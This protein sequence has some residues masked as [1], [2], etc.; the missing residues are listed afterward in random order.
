MQINGIYGKLCLPE[1]EVDII[2][3]LMI[4]IGRENL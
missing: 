3:V 2:S 4:G 1:S